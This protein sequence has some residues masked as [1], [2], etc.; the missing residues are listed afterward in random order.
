MNSSKVPPV[1]FSGLSCHPLV[2]SNKYI[3]K[4][5]LD[6]INRC[7]DW[8]LVFCNRRRGT[9]RRKGGEGG[10]P[11]KRIFWWEGLFHPVSFQDFR[12][13]PAT[14]YAH[15]SVQLYFLAAR[16]YNR[17]GSRRGIAFDPGIERV[18]VCER[19]REREGA[20]EDSDAVLTTMTMTIKS[21]SSPTF[22]L[23]EKG[24]TD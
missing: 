22:E 13:Q 2:S 6:R 5:H 8:M 9:E 3:K 1:F 7:L 20:R 18:C 21:Q 10:V 14:D 24:E 15:L 19:K 12:R 16:T 17:R 11:E 23:S 4:I